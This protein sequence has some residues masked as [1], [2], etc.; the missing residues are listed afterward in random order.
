MGR[1][2]KFQS[3]G[4]LRQ[5]LPIQGLRQQQTKC[6]YCSFAARRNN[7]RQSIHENHLSSEVPNAISFEGGMAD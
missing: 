4:N 5:P 6:D 2:L 7:S 3:V 1:C